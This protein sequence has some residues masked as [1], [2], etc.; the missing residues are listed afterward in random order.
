MK[1]P[2]YR[3]MICTHN[4]NTYSPSI[5]NKPF[6]HLH[7]NLFQLIYNN[8]GSDLILLKCGDMVTFALERTKNFQP[9][10]LFN[11]LLY[12]FT[13]SSSTR[14]PPT[15]TYT[16]SD[17]EGQPTVR[18]QGGRGQE[19]RRN[20]IARQLCATARREVYTLG[21]GRHPLCISIPYCES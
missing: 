9:C 15:Q 21:F 12:M 4:H 8:V 7:T 5:Q 3:Y 17:D 6:K 1:P 14:T 19:N 20:T 16:T 10:S 2:L 11:T 18:G 13:S